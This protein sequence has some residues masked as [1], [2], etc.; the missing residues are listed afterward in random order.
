L[1]NPSEE[2]NTSFTKAYENTLRKHHNMLVRPVFGVSIIL[3]FSFFKKKKE[4]DARNA[5]RGRKRDRY[6]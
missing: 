1:E 6:M 4:E 3:L 5:G 2:L